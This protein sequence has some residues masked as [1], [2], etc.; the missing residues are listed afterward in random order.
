MFGPDLQLL[1]VDVVPVIQHTFS[2]RMFGWFFFYSTLNLET[3]NLIVNYSVIDLFWDER[4]QDFSLFTSYQ[5]LTHFILSDKDLI[6]VLWKIKIFEIPVYNDFVAV[7][8]QGKGVL[9][10]RTLLFKRQE[11]WTKRGSDKLFSLYCILS[12]T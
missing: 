12:F 3:S 7:V 6:W 4:W 11:L 9:L 1:N 2:Q 8:G 5:S 10:Y